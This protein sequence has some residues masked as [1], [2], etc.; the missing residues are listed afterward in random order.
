MLSSGLLVLGLAILRLAILRLAV[1]LGLI[2]GAERGQ[3]GEG[4][5]RC[6]R[7]RRDKA[8]GSSNL[9]GTAAA[10]E[11]HLHL[12][13]DNDAVV[14]NRKSA[15]REKRLRDRTVLVGRGEQARKGET[16]AS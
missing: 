11:G 2:L 9:R 16:S 4:R 5:G 8:E 3:Q 1:L 14:R 13:R 10:A 12:R 6:A 15:K 7:G